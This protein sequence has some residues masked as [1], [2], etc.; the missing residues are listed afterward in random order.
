MNKPI[1]THAHTHIYIY[2]EKDKY[3]DG[4]RRVQIGIKERKKKQKK[5]KKIK[6]KR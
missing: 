2:I 6:K 1:Y 5:Q 4:F 3:I